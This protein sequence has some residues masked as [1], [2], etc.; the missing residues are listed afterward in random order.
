MGPVGDLSRQLTEAVT[1]H[2]LA[3]LY[4]ADRYHHME[5]EI[6]PHLEADPEVT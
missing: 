4:A 5:A 2:A 1:G 6:R 3:C